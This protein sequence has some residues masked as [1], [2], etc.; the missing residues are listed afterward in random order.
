MARRC[1][2][3]FDNITRFL[4]LHLWKILNK[5][6]NIF[7]YILLKVKGTSTEQKF[8]WVESEC[9]KMLIAYLIFPWFF[10]NMYKNHYYLKK[11]IIPKW[12]L[13]F[14]YKYIVYII[15]DLFFF[16]SSP[17]ATSLLINC[18]FHLSKH[19]F[20]QVCIKWSQ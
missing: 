20:Y 19:F 6:Y 12:H 7:Y 10:S 16:H 8:S 2:L 4:S 11:K 18:K 15:S 5:T 14:F 17:L 9:Y 3:W 1:T 13:Y